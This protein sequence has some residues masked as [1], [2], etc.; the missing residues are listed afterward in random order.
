VADFLGLGRAASI[1]FYLP[2]FHPIPQNDRAWGAGFTEWRSVV[3]AR[4]V[5]RGHLQPN[6]PADLGFYD[7]RLPDTQAAQVALAQRYAVDALCYYHY[8]FSGQRLLGAPLDALRAT[9][10]PD[11]PFCLCWANE[12]WRS[13]WDGG[14][15]SILVDQEHSDDDDL[16]HIRWLLPVF[17]DARYLRIDGKPLFLVYRAHLLA[18]PER[19]TDA[20]R[21]EADRAGVGE[22]F[23]CRVESFRNERDDPRSLGFDAAVEFQPDWR[24]LPPRMRGFG[25]HAVY[26]YRALAD[27]ALA[28][29]SVPWR[30]FSCVTP[31]WDNTPRRR[32]GAIFAGSTPERYRAWLA[33]T[34]LRAADG[35]PVFINAWNEWGE[36]AYL[37]PDLEWGHQYLEAHE[38]A[39]THPDVHAAELPLTPGPPPMLDRLRAR[40]SS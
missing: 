40:F 5:Y 17:T 35:E 10:Q 3:Q 14:T 23:L 37:E 25:A 19:T 27:R 13:N 11:H 28:K 20:W 6:L 30:R 39:M 29:P 36:G 1:A 12:P 4:P 33:S 31:R 34:V 7:L 18:S 2:Q 26:D 9:G 32:H 38:Q 22:L 21:R 15:G 16:D 8:W 24:A